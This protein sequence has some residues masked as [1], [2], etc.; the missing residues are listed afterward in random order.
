MDH[1][2]IL[3][4][5]GLLCVLPLF[6]FF[7]NHSSY[8]VLWRRVLFSSWKP[9]HWVWYWERCFDSKWVSFSRVDH[10]NFSLSC[11]WK[12][13]RQIK[14]VNFPIKS[15]FFLKDSYIYILGSMVGPPCP[16]SCW[17]CRRSNMAPT[18]LCVCVSVCL[19]VIHVYLNMSD[20]KKLWSE[21]YQMLVGQ[22]H[23]MKRTQGAVPSL[24]DETLSLV[25]YCPN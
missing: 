12:P 22:F 1:R 16:T 18:S 15:F 17:S 20:R 8:S 25:F 7:L 19:Y 24:V 3:V 4:L 23:L 14:P 5:F 13:A 2:Q 9:F 6:S 21:S 10:V 11:S